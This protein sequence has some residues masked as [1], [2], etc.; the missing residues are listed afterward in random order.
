MVQCVSFVQPLR[1]R[2]ELVDTQDQESGEMAKKAST[3]HSTEVKE[4]GPTGIHEQREEDAGSCG[5][6]GNIVEANGRDGYDESSQE[7]EFTNSYAH[8]NGETLVDDSTASKGDDQRPAND[9]NLESDV[10][11]AS[12][13]PTLSETERA[14]VAS[15]QLEKKSQGKGEGL[16]KDPKREG[17]V[18][19]A[20]VGVQTESSPGSQALNRD[21]QLPCNSG[22][23]EYDNVACG[24]AADTEQ[25][26]IPPPSTVSPHKQ[27]DDGAISQG[28]GGESETTALLLNQMDNET[29]SQ[30]QQVELQLNT[31]RELITQGQGEEIG[32]P[33]VPPSQ[34]VD[35][36]I[37][38]G[39]GHE[40]TVPL[41]N[42]VIT[43]GQGE[44]TKLATVPPLEQTT[45]MRGVVNKGDNLSKGVMKFAS[46]GVQTE[47]TTPAK[48]Q[49]LP[50]TLDPRPPPTPTAGPI[51]ASVAVQCSLPL[52]S[53]P[54]LLEKS[55]QTLTTT[56]KDT[57]V[58][59][60]EGGSKSC[61]T[62]GAEINSNIMG[63]SPGAEKHYQLPDVGSEIEVLRKE[64]ESM[65]NT[66]IWQ[67]LMLRLY[68]EH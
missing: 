5:H 36:A 9:R 65:Q 50:L 21:N 48:P 8:G 41:E 1:Y 64:L 16:E 25:T 38:Q 3:S 27:N 37:T 10:A 15:H 68:S 17:A 12:P 33:A 28:Q 2:R 24:S 22:N 35:E 13:L 66:V 51:S 46:V 19:H 7:R 60:T 6:T 30:K 44:W 63:S 11:S 14:I 49:P 23:L 57:A 40:S 29:L 45:S 31:V 42:E 4:E 26:T 62:G 47:P 59:T 55:T 67:A 52:A 58:K 39:Q 18:R 20:S 43:H 32:L 61:R 34:Q 56:N 54:S 53:S